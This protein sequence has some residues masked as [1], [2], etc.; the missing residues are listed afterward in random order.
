LTSKPLVT[1]REIRL[2]GRD[3]TLSVTAPGSYDIGRSRE[4]PLRV[5]DATVSRRH[6][7]IILADDRR[8]AWVEHAGGANGTRLNGNAVMAPAPLSDGD[9]VEVGELPLM[10]TLVR[11]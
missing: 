7:R 10:V 6:A 3:T 1:I 2:T 11:G 5:A 8:T 4:V 9:K